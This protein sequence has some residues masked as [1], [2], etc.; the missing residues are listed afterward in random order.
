[1]NRRVQESSVP[2]RLEVTETAD[3]ISGGDGVRQITVFGKAKA[4]RRGDGADDFGQHIIAQMRELRIRRADL[5][6]AITPRRHNA[7]DCRIHRPRVLVDLRLER[8]E[9][10]LGVH[11]QSLHP[12]REAVLD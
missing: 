7:V 11:L 12:E 9:K 2:P 6:A 10:F 5:G 8:G 1:M 3:A 4:S